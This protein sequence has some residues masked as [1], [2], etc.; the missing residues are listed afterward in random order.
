VRYR[1]SLNGYDQFRWKQKSQCT[2]YCLSRIGAAR[3]RSVVVLVETEAEAHILWHHSVPA[4]ALTSDWDEQR[5]APHFDGIDNII[6]AVRDPKQ[7][8]SRSIIRHRTKLLP[9]DLSGIIKLI[10]EN[11][12]KSKILTG[13]IPWGVIEAQSIDIEHAEAELVCRDLA[14]SPDILLRLDRDL[15]A[16]G[17][18]G[19]RNAARLLYLAII[20]QDLKKPNSVLVK[21]ASSVGKSYTVDKVLKFFPD[22]AVYRFSTVS[23]K[24]LVLSDEPFSHRHLYFYEAAGLGSSLVLYFLRTLISKVCSDITPTGSASRSRW[25]RKVRPLQS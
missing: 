16:V 1:V 17:L 20:S 18:V 2:L 8:L 5:D 14:L 23:E 15:E 22:T 3:K 24:Q 11:Q 6:V 7:W 9:L 21:A 13:G 19:E 10:V 12:L 4:L 25:S